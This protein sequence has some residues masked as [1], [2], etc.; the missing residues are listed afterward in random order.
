ML[1]V[2]TS[3]EVVEAVLA[4]GGLFGSFWAW[5]VRAAEL[6]TKVWSVLSEGRSVLGW[7]KE[8]MRRW[9]LRRV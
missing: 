9:R 5:E 8:W 4:K 7:N 3:V 1:C 6:G 2:G